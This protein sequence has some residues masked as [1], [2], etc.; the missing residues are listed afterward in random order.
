MDA[1]QV[2]Q[3]AGLLRNQGKGYEAAIKYAK[4]R[5]LYEQ[6]SDLKN[7]AGCQHMIGVSYK[8]EDNLEKAIPALKEAL[9]LYEQAG[10]LTGPGRVWRDMGIMYAYH[11]KYAEAEELLLQSQNSL[12]SITPEAD[13]DRDAELGITIVKIGLLHLEMERF[14]AAEEQMMS[15]LLLI[16]KAGQSFYEMTALMHL[17]S[18]YFA[19]KHYGR[20]LANLQAA[21]GIIY[22]F[23]MQHEQTRRLA[24]IWGLLAHG[25]IHHQNH[26]TATYF[27]QKA[28]AEI[29][30]MNPDAQGPIL[31]HIQ[32]NLLRKQLAL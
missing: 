21:L 6:A 5:T 28:L 16:R 29:K 22:E 30:T 17:G 12:E 8:V 19:T 3:A 15:G 7:A 2:E 4:A 20:M 18:L 31:K 9:L 27:A 14:P 13:A 23:D 26:K 1:Q 24:E 10:S 25:Y 32:A 11:G